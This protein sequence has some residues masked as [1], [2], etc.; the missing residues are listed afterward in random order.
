MIFFG[1]KGAG[2]DGHNYWFGG[3]D[4]AAAS[5]IWTVK[6][7]NGQDY[8]HPTQKPTAL[9]QRAIKNSAPPKG[10][11]YEPFSGSGSTLIACEIE[12]RRCRAMELDPGY[13]DVAVRRWEDFTGRVATLEATGQTF[14]EVSDERRLAAAAA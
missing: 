11:V 4:A 9:A 8:L 14:R 13:V 2:G 6:R 3:R 1:W 10:I 5:D 7:D 12:G